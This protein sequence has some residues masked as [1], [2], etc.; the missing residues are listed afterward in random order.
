M[1]QLQRLEGPRCQNYRENLCI[2]G[3]C[4]GTNSRSLECS[5]S[6]KLT[7]NV[8]WSIAN[9]VRGSNLQYVTYLYKS[10]RKYI[11]KDMGKVYFILLLGYEKIFIKFGPRMMLAKYQCTCYVSFKLVLHFIYLECVPND[12]PKISTQ[13]I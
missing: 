5:R 7:Q 3:P 12:S 1:W 11:F 6:M 8:V 10:I 13:Y 4:L 9:I 2:L